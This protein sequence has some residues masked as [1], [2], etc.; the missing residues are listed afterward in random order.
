VRDAAVGGWWLAR[1]W[2]RALLEAVQLAV[3]SQKQ[4]K[5]L[6]ALDV[7]TAA[8]AHCCC[9]CHFCYQLLAAARAVVPAVV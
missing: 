4:L 9:C 8:A 2:L 7:A 3:T 6:A 1:L 5:G